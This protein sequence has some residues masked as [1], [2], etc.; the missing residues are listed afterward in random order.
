MLIISLFLFTSFIW[1]NNTVASVDKLAVIEALVVSNPEEALISIEKIRK[2]NAQ[3]TTAQKVM[4]IKHEVVA[5]TYLN[6]HKLALD[7]IERIKEI[8][9]GE[10]NKVFLWHY[11]NTKAIVFWHMDSIEDSLGSHLDAY[12][13]VKS[14]DEFRSFQATSEGNIGYIFIKLGFF[15]QATSYLESSLAFALTQN[16]F[17]ILATNYNNLGEAYLGLKKY[18]KSFEL[19]D[20]SLEIRLEHNLTFHSSYSYQNLGLLY[21]GQKQYQQAEVAFN[22][23]IEIR[24]RAGF[25]KGVL[26][27]QLALAKTYIESNQI[28]LA[29]DKI[30]AVIE[31]SKRQNNNTN[32]SEAYR[33]QRNIYAMKNDYQN[34]YQASLLYE[35]ASEQVVSRKTS[36]KLAN[37]LNTS[38]AISKDLNILELENNAKIKDLQVNS[39]RQ[40][41]KIIMTFGF[42]L[43][44]IL[45]IF[46]W[47]VQRSKKVIAKSNTNLYLTLTEL[48]ETQEKLVKAGKMSA[49]TTLV[50]RMA[51][52]VNTPLGIAVTGVSHIHEKVECFEKL[53]SAGG[54]KKSAIDSLLT[55]LNKGCELSSNSMNKVAG[56][57]SQFKMIS[58]NLEAES[59]QEFEI[60]DHISK[61]ADLILM[62][63]KKSKPVI[64]ISGSKV[65]ILGFPEALNK[66]FDQLITNSIDHAFEDT[67]APE[68]D[69][70][71]V[72]INGH[73]EIIYQDNGKGIDATMVNDVFEPFYT[74][75]MGNKNLGIGLSIV[76]NLVVQLMQGNIQCKTKKGQGIMFSIT[77]PLIVKAV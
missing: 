50:S 26:V 10:S 63:L 75:N 30:G 42:C 74:T 4:L 54:I 57:I 20:R 62:A 49:L 45:T 38:K 9:D 72:K 48:K 43:V 40:K 27:S 69:I 28:L 21:Y 17:I 35:Q 12:D 29:E 33:L 76:Y 61:Q 71:I 14:I 15:K 23:A 65:L 8:A 55:D 22:K 25:V 70:E 7:N 77:L 47:T 64:N 1:A 5:N 3:L 34:A 2:N 36:T 13:V 44:I 31:G 24:E 67:L 51:H 68:I 32:L 11:Y 60:F 46:L 37:Y 59:Q 53:I 19:L 52:Q 16:D 58:D 41:A 56:L 73:I 6:H 39:D 66:V 18:T